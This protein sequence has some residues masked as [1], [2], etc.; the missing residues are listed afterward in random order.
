MT[1]VRIRPRTLVPRALK[2][3]LRVVVERHGVENEDRFP[4]IKVVVVEGKEDITINIP[5]GG[6]LRSA[7]PL[8]P[9]RL[10]PQIRNVFQ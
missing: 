10:D 7:I 9:R 2:N 8:A 3:S 1:H 5:D 4:P 6:I